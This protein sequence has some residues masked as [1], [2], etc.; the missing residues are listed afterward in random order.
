MARRYVHGSMV[1]AAALCAGLFGAAGAATAHRNLLVLVDA[2]SGHVVSSFRLGAEP[3][4]VSYGAR[5]FWVVAPGARTIVRIDPRD[6]DLQRRK[7]GVEPFDVAARGGALWIADHDGNDVLRVDLRGRHNLTSADLRNPQLAIAYG[8]G[9]VWVVG[10]DR[11]LRRL[12]P[13]TL[14]VT[15]TVDDV[16]ASI[17]EYEPKIAVGR[18]ALWISDAVRC[19]VVRVDPVRLRVTARVHRAG[20]GVALSS[21]GVWSTDSFGLAERVAGGKVATV[22]TGR[23]AVDV[24]AGGGSIWVVN[25]FVGTIVRVDPR[26]RRVTKTIHVGGMPVAV[27]YGDGYV[28]AAVR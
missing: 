8:L 28:A 18:D 20:F 9:A 14:A 2:R 16:A 23:G 21:D 11:I 19:A 26:R 6:P 12:D 4:R 1:A 17:E 10:A 7:V 22:K 3:L 15:G 25:R 24:A 13:A 5:A 27:A